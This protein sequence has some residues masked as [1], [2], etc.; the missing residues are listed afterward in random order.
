M[1]DMCEAESPLAQTTQQKLLSDSMKV[2]DKVKKL[3]LSGDMQAARLFCDVT[4]GALNKGTFNQQELS[5]NLTDEQ[6][7]KIFHLAK[8]QDV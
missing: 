1:P 3:S 7:L 4:F 2:L 5:L 6:A 8:N